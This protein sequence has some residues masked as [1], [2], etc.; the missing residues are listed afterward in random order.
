MI[1]VMTKEKKRLLMTKEEKATMKVI[2]Y[3]K[4]IKMSIV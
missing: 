3:L 1:L 4:P 2:E